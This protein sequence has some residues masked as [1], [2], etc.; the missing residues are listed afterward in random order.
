MQ[1]AILDR[2]VHNAHMIRIQGKE[3]MRKKKG[4]AAAG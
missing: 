3:S 4:L 2:I 1:D